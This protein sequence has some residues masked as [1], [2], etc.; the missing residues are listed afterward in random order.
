M[1]AILSCCNIGDVDENEALLGGQQNGYGVDNEQDDS[2]MKRQMKEQ[3][4]RALAREAHLKEIVSNTNDK[5]IDISM[6]SNS[7]IVVQG[8]DIKSMNSGIQDSTISQEGE[9]PYRTGN[10]KWIPL[11][12]K[13]Y[14]PQ[15]VRREL[16]NIHKIVFSQLDKELKLEPPGKLTVTL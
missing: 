13:K 10:R 3:E 7:G 1:G 2:E 15:K 12:T 8:S 11:D 6:I 5:L 4:E 9:T 16:K 14:M